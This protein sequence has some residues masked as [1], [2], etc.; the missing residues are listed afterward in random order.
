MRS[1]FRC[2]VAL[3]ALLGAC[4][5]ATASCASSTSPSALDLTGTWSGTIG[6]GSGG[7]RAVRVTWTISQTDATVSGPATLSASPA[8]AAVAF[9]GLLTGTLHG[10]EVSLAF[11]SSLGNV[12]GTPNCSLSGRGVATIAGNSIAGTF[13]VIYT[14]CESLN[15]Q[16]PAS[17]QFLL[18]KQ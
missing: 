11:T 6:S 17:D 2:S 4:A 5:L 18:T 10:S 3:V 7:G 1:P 13:D 15:L 12:P 14:A 9:P 16:P 8:I